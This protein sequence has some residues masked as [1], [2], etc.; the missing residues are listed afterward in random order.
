MRDNNEYLTIRGGNSSYEA[1]LRLIHLNLEILNDVYDSN[2]AMSPSAKKLID[3]I[4]EY[5]LTLV[6]HY[7]Q[8]KANAII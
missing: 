6:S 3:S 5:V 4:Y 7:K 2:I 8:L 1:K